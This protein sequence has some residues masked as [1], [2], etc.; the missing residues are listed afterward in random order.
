VPK[1]PPGRPAPRVR[2]A[3][4][5][6]RV[7]KAQQAPRERKARQARQAPKEHKAP[8]VQP[9]QRA[10]RAT[11]ARQARQARK[12]RKVFKAPKVRKVR[13]VH[14]VRREYKA[15]KAWQVHRAQPVLKDRKGSWR[16]SCR[17]P[18]FLGGADAQHWDV[19]SDTPFPINQLDPGEVIYVRASNAGVVVKTLWQGL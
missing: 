11:L 1:A 10:T 7:H 2:L 4:R 12:D 19:S 5:V 15:P 3:P 8:P 17:R 9:A 13:T 6:L 18:I 14:K 16:A